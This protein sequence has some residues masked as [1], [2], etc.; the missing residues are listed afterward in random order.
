MCRIGSMADLTHADS[1]IIDVPPS[2]AYAAISDITRMGE[3]S[4]VCKECWWD[5]G[6]G[7]SVGSYFTGRNE[8]PTRTW[9]TRSQVVV[10]DVDR[11]F[12]WSVSDGRVHWT[13]TF[14]P[15]D[16]GTKVTESWVFTE[17]GQAFFE[18]RFGD[19]APQEVAARKASA[20]AGIPATLAAM[21]EALERR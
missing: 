15:V 18:D 1:I 21:K 19:T 6:H 11:A 5:E 20:E 9:E 3:W 16:G 2:V 7:P 17:K 4:P 12:G 8:T 10:A 14:E 13:Y